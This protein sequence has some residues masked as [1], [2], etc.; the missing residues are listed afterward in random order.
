[1]VSIGK[2][3]FLFLTPLQFAVIKEIAEK[4]PYLYHYNS[5][6]FMGLIFY[7]NFI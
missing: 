3:K 5:N 2:N 6:Q 4:L 7:L 1:M